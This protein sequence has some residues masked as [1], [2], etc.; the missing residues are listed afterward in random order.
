MY[1]E[2]EISKERTGR[3][4]GGGGRMKELMN[5]SLQVSL[6]GSWYMAREK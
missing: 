5:I 2:K 3:V 4:G 1:I 6:I